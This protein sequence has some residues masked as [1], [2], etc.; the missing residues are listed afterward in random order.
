MANARRVLVVGF[1]ADGADLRRGLLQ[2]GYLPLEVDH[3]DEATCEFE[4]GTPLA[5][6]VFL[7]T[8]HPGDGMASAVDRLRE[9]SS[10]RI[11]LV[12]VG[13]LPE[14][15]ARRLLQRAGVTTCLFAPFG[16]EEL[17]RVIDA[18][19]PALDRD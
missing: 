9:A 13:A 14:P 4:R 5:Q 16:F 17:R 7:S 19:L 15:G 10:D 2:L 8:G 6:L 3:L 12:G 1:G 18:M 11:G